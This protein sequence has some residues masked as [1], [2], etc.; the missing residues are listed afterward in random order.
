[1]NVSLAAVCFEDGCDVDRLFSEIASRQIAR[2]K[3][4]CGVLQVRGISQGKC[5]CSDMDLQSI[6]SERVF[7]ISQSLGQGAAGCRLHPGALAEC[8]AYLQQKIEDGCDLLI[9]NRFGKE[10]WRAVA[11]EI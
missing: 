6:G 10:N 3:R 7:R 2:S 11:S 5:H 8:S 1:M 9:L 4:V